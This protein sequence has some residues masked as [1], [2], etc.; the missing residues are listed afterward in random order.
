MRSML[1]STKL[2]I[3]FLIF[4]FPNLVLVD[5]YYAAPGWANASSDKAIQLGTL[6]TIDEVCQLIDHPVFT[7]K[8]QDSNLREP[9]KQSYFG[10][11]ADETPYTYLF[12]PIDNVITEFKSMFP[13]RYQLGRD[14]KETF[15]MMQNISYFPECF[16]KARDI[17]VFKSISPVLIQEQNTYGT[18]TDYPLIQW[19]ERKPER[20]VR[21]YYSNLV[22][23]GS[24]KLS[25]GAEGNT[26]CMGCIF[27]LK[28]IYSS[29]IERFDELYAAEV[30]RLKRAV[31]HRKVAEKYRLEALLLLNDE[32]AA[33]L[34]LQEV[35][36]IEA[37]KL[38]IEKINIDLNAERDAALLA[39]KEEERFRQNSLERRLKLKIEAE[40]RQE[41]QN[42]KIFFIVFV[43][44]IFIARYL[45]Q[46]REF[47]Y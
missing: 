23:V 35:I 38:R 28:E 24:V 15:Q 7:I 36:S 44:S 43:I 20:L 6:A 31:A 46:K 40:E 22:S 11:G 8:Q 10:F 4:V 14:K 17:G 34:R 3:A 1:H 13:A 32:E 30:D 25:A 39:S 2:L 19:T 9:W 47:K 16:I 18:Q 29:L 41:S 5:D 33:K 42:L 12:I 26:T 37:E 45:F 27:F 21:E